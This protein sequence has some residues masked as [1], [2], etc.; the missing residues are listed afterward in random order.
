MQVHTEKKVA[1][2]QVALDYLQGGVED[3]K[4]REQCSGKYG[5]EDTQLCMRENFFSVSI[6][7]IIFLI[8]QKTFEYFSSMSTVPG[9]R[10]TNW[11]LPGVSQAF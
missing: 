8:I 6:H 7:R 5:R 2:F 1:N 4:D 11:V 10:N 9:M 3:T